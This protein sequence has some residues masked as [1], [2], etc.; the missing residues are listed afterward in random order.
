MCVWRLITLK[1]LNRFGW[2]LHRDLQYIKINPFRYFTPFQDGVSYSSLDGSIL[3]IHYLRKT[4]PLMTYSWTL[5]TFGN[6]CFNHIYLLL[7]LFVPLTST[8]YFCRFPL[9]LNLNCVFFF[10]VEMVSSS[11]GIVGSVLGGCEAVGRRQQSHWNLASWSFPTSPILLRAKPGSDLDG[12]DLD[13]GSSTTRCPEVDARMW[14]QFAA[15][16]RPLHRPPPTWWQD[17]HS[18]VTLAIG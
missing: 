11:W 14:Q 7:L 10:I 4:V 8:N 12:L 3:L 13:L 9:G 1:R 2:F 5:I 6:L 18:S 15:S 17:P 16:P